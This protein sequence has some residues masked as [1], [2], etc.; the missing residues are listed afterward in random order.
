MT[1]FAWAGSPWG[2]VCLL[3]DWDLS[4][5]FMWL[6]LRCPLTTLLPAH[7]AFLKWCLGDSYYPPSGVS[8]TERG[9][10]VGVCG[11]A[12]SL[13]WVS[14]ALTARQ[15]FPAESADRSSISFAFRRSESAAWGL[16][17]QERH[18]WSPNCLWHGSIPP[19][20]EPS[21]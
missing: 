5:V 15:V 8:N 20:F 17:G 4:R 6:L 11:T 2:M 9:D 21:A 13:A 16:L 10:S 3:Q 12:G 18:D 14:N 19:G 1:G 7:D